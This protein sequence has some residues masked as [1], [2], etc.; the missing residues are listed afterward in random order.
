M[1]INKIE[2]DGFKGIGDLAVKSKNFNVII[3]KNNTSKSSLLEAIAYA[4][5]VNMGVSFDDLHH[6]IK[7]YHRTD[8]HHRERIELRAP[9][10]SHIINV[11]KKESKIT[12]KL[13]NDTKEIRFYRP[14]EVEFIKKFKKQIIKDV[15]FLLKRTLKKMLEF[16]NSK[17]D[18]NKQ[19]TSKKIKDDLDELGKII[20]RTFSDDKRFLDIVE[21]CVVLEKK[22]GT[23]LLQHIY[24]NRNL[25]KPI[26]DWFMKKE[27]RSIVLFSLGRLKLRDSDSSYDKLPVTFINTSN[28]S[29]FN[30]S[31]RIAKRIETY[32]QDTGVFDNIGEL[33]RFDQDL[34]FRGKN[35]KEFVI[36]Y[37]QMGDGSKS[38]ID[39]VAKINKDSE[40]ILLEELET[41]MHPEYVD[42]V[43]TKLID[44]SKT[45]NMQFFITTHNFD[46]LHFLVSDL[47]EPDHRKYLDK[48]LQ[49]IR[50]ENIGSEITCTQFDRKSAKSIINGINDD[51]RGI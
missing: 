6:R 39:I 28:R 4:I 14:T 27:Y 20:D 24:L 40:I 2:I 19:N 48:E 44:I 7:F 3:G 13:E 25:P 32:L 1:K 35:G 21:S 36:P 17:S 37:S 45:K 5:S 9:V 51:L 18:K 22:D 42:M 11:K 15:E 16:G 41:H 12:I 38:L 26:E 50:M 33:S 8:S 30:F 31:S 49:I 29:S 43:L 46:V 10:L 47:M 23:E 34:L